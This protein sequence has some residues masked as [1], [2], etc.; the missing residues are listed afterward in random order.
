MHQLSTRKKKRE[1]NDI[2]GIVQIKI[3]MP[4]KMAPYE[5]I[6]LRLVSRM[7]VLKLVHRLKLDDIQTIW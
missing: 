3:V 6:D 2:K 1:T 4:I 7:Q 5:F